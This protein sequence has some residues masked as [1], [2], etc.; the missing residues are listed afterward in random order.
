M[1]IGTS[2]L[3]FAAAFFVHYF[4]T[5]EIYS[6]STSDV[7]CLALNIYWEARSDPVEGQLA[8][9]H[10]AMNRVR[11]RAYP[12]TVCKVIYQGDRSTPGACQFS[13]WCDKRSDQPTEYRA[14]QTSQKLARRV[15]DGRS[16]DPTGGA[17]FY[18]LHTISPYWS[19]K[20]QR[21]ARIGSHIYYR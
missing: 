8:V 21:I 18:H 14:W 20:K 7:K 9:A 6:A 16:L 4:T 15:L 19:A 10:V 12:N 13:W 2:G 17:L 1:L 11:S 3:L 5:E